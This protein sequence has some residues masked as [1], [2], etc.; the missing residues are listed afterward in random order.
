[1]KLAIIRRR[2]APHGGAERFIATG[3]RALHEAGVDISIVA[4]SWPG[5]GAYRTIAA[6]ARGITRAARL[7][8][9]QSAVA[10]VLADGTFDLVQSHER[11]LTADIF[12]AGDGVHAAW[13]ARQMK[14][15]GGLRSVLMR[16]DPM[17]RLLIDTERRMA[18]DT[19]MIF[20]AN[21]ALVAREIGD[22]LSVP[23]ARI[24]II[25]NGVD[26]DAFRPPD[27]TERTAARRRYGMDANVP[28]AA[29]VGSGFERK[30]V[31]A[32]VEALARPDA[33]DIHALIAGADRSLD[34]IK[35]R[36]KALGLSAR[37]RVLG[38]VSDPLSVYHAADIYVLPSLY[39]P[40]PNAALEALA[41][42]LPVVTTADTGVADAVAGAGAGCIVT[43]DPDSIV[44]GLAAAFGRRPAM[45]SAASALA[46]RFSLEQATAHWLSLYRELA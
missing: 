29:F 43:R 11:V 2:Y 39:D 23:A 9:F 42:G 35:A 21:S 30:G 7:R 18:R 44:H 10:D 27:E 6:P 33:K 38:G 45:A 15:R 46:Q 20:V 24:R 36:V 8:R 40:M 5:G 13:V 14:D 31:F 32:L 4:E 12:R 41:C 28:V 34:A 17:H 16:L 3:S 26:L 37:I 1:M 19:D 22:W 25:E